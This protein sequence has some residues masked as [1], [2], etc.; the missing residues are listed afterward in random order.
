M[1]KRNLIIGGAVVAG[2]AIV[3][4]LALPLSNLGMREV[5]AIFLEKVQD[6]ALKELLP[7]FKN[8]CLDC[9]STGAQL[10]FYAGLPGISGQVQADRKKALAWWDVDLEWLEGDIPEASLAKIQQVLED[11]NMPPMMY[12]TLHWKSSVTDEESQAILSWI[13]SK[14]A[15]ANGLDP[16]DKLVSRSVLPMQKR[17]VPPA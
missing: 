5:D 6:P 17:P 8:K 1:G 11:G 14:R 7:I 13:R 15:K 2:L 4:G 16:T 3:A 12:K 10:P 9:H